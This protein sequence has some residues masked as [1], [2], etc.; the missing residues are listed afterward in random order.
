[1]LGREEVMNEDDSA[2]TADEDAAEEAGDSCGTW[3]AD[4][5]TVGS[6]ILATVV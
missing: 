5:A 4:D 3:I 2:A 6:W 1:V